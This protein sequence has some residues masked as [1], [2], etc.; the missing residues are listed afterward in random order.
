MDEKKLKKYLKKNIKPAANITND[1]IEVVDYE[2]SGK[3]DVD[4][5]IENNEFTSVCPRTGFPDFGK[6]TLQYTPDKKIIEL[7]S[8]K[9]YLLQYRNTGIFYEHIVNKILNALI[10]LVQPKFMKVT[11]EFTIRGGIKTPTKTH[12]S[13]KSFKSD[14]AKPQQGPD[15]RD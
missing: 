13:S 6:I 15:P 14:S 10:Q 12:Y 8:L 5:V 3:V 7:K 11:G 2:Y 9:Y 1:M 4:I